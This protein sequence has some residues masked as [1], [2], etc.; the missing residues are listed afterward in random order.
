MTKAQLAERVAEL[1]RA[2]E[3]ALAQLQTVGGKKEAAR[4]LRGVLNLEAEA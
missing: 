4:I 2:A 3:D 1:E